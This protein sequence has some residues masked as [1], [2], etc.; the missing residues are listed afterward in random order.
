[1][2]GVVAGG[3][4]LTDF[5]TGAPV[6]TLTTPGTPGSVSTPEPSATVLLGVGLLAVGLAVLGF[7]PRFAIDAPINQTQEHLH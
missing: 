7:K 2:L 1:M 3:V 5:M 6:G 4:A